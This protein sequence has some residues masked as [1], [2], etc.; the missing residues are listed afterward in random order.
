MQFV[1]AA[2]SSSAFIRSPPS[3]PTNVGLLCVSCRQLKTHLMTMSSPYN[4]DNIQLTIC[5][6]CIQSM[7]KF[8]KTPRCQ[9][10]R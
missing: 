1:T 6:E 7:Q 2:V 9:Y 4:T 10:N 8:A 3:S 5:L